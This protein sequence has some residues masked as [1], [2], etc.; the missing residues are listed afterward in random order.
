[1]LAPSQID[2]LL[3]LMRKLKAEGR[4]IV[5]ISHKLEEVLNVADAITVMR[6]GRV[7]ATTTA[8]A[9]SVG[10]LARAMVGEAVE[11][12]RVEPRPRP[13]GA[14]LFSARGLVGADAMGFE[15][16][17]PVD[18]D[19][20]AG[21]IVGIAGV[22]GN[23]QDELVACASGLAVPVAG[24][25]AF[26]GQDLTGSPTSRFRAAGVGYVSADRG[27]EGLCLTAPIRDNFVAGREREPPFSHLGTA[28]DDRRRGAEGAHA[29]FGSFRSARRPRREPLRRQSAAPRHRARTRPRT[30]N[31]SSPRNRRE[32][33][34]SQG[35]RSSKA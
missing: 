11:T 35:R 16:L 32:A 10:E 7:V 20:F 13:A 4:T 19:M 21:E 3:A 27:E 29:A 18:L 8:A 12:A 14:P 23:G 34:T 5:F 28:R 9:T 17:G 22:G 2:D 15:R 30:E 25:I 33:S 1:M 26:D 6:S 24:T 31:S